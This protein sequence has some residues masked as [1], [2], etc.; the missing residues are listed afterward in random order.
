[1]KHKEKW[2]SESENYIISILITG[3]GPESE[4][5]L[6]TRKKDETNMISRYKGCDCRSESA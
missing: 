3:H 5:L 2:H 6:K 1:M 4:S